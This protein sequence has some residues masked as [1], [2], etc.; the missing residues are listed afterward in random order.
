MFDIC[1]LWEYNVRKKIGEGTFMLNTGLRFAYGYY[2]Y[3][4][5]E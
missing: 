5:T 3:F 1:F 2:F 4:F